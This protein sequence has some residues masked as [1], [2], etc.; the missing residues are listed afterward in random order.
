MYG[1]IHVLLNPTRRL[2]PAGKQSYV[3]HR[4]AHVRH[5]VLTCA[6]H[7]EGPMSRRLGVLF[8]SSKMT[9]SI[10]IR[11]PECTEIPIVS[12]CHCLT[13]LL[14]AQLLL[15]QLLVLLV[16]VQPSFATRLLLA[17]YIYT[18]IHLYIYRSYTSIESTGKATISPQNCKNDRIHSGSLPSNPVGSIG[19]FGNFLLPFLLDSKCQRYQQYQQY[20]QTISTVLRVILQ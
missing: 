2:F 16:L 6:N 11:Q 19:E 9:R 5:P 17:R 20:Q 8:P 15:I 4:W 7:I 3:D 14:V 13:S 18:S 1:S 12:L 10:F